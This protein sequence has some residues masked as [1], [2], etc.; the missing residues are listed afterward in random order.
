MTLRPSALALGL[1]L[2]CGA[3]ALAQ[4]ASPQPSRTAPARPAPQAQAAPPA[5]AAVAP[6]APAQPAAPQ[7][8]RTEIVV[9]DGWTAT[10]RDFADKKRTCT[11]TLQV[12]Q[13]QNNQVIFNWIL[14][15][16]A[17]NKLLSV[18]QTPTGVSI[19]PGVEVKLARGNPRKAAYGQSIKFALP[20]KGFDKAVAAVR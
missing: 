16:N 12:V 7:P 1:S 3:Q 17:D 5:P 13:Q 8:I 19:A 9:H 4:P 20:F 15:K 2:L 18:L 10:C 14:G 11:A 6:A